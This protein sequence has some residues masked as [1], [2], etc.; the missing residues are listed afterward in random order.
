MT[1]GDC[2]LTQEE[3]NH[4]V[5]EGDYEN[6]HHLSTVIC[7]RPLTCASITQTNQLP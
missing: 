6:S 5:W 7:V 3:A 4:D 1:G 2:V